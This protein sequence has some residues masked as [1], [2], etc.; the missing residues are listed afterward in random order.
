MV[1]ESSIPLGDK[2]VHDNERIA[3]L[4]AKVCALELEKRITVIHN[5]WAAFDGTNKSSEF[6]EGVAYAMNNYKPE[7]AVAV[8][9]VTDNT[10]INSAKLG[11]HVGAI[12]EDAVLKKGGSDL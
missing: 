12:D 8:A 1:D 2:H 3:A 10:A 11:K 7:K 9:E 4:E 6:L 5:K